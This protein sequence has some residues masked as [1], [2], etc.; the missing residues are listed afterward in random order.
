MKSKGKRNNQRTHYYLRFKSRQSVKN[1]E[2]IKVPL[3]TYVNISINL[4][5]PRGEEL[6]NVLVAA[7]GVSW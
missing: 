2:M 3:E 5:I 1:R 4:Q 6:S 7:A